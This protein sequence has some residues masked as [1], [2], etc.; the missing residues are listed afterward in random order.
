DYY[1]EGEGSLLTVAHLDSKAHATVSP[2]GLIDALDQ[3]TGL[4]YEIDPNAM[5]VG[6]GVNVVRREKFPA[7]RAIVQSGSKVEVKS[8]NDLLYFDGSKPVA[9]RRVCGYPQQG[10]ANYFAPWAI[11][12]VTHD[13]YGYCVRTNTLLILHGTKLVAHLSLANRPRSIAF[14]RRRNLVYLQSYGHVVTVLHGTKRVGTVHVPAEQTIGTPVVDPSTGD[15]YLPGYNIVYVV[16]RT[17]YLGSVA[18]GPLLVVDPATHRVYAG[19]NGAQ[20]L[21][22]KGAEVV[23]HVAT[24]ADPAVYDPMDRAVLAA[25]GTGLQVIHGAKVEQT[26]VIPRVTSASRIAVVPSR[27]LIVAT[28]GA[29]V[30]VL[31]S[32]AGASS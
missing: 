18:A 7:E 23:G 28:N 30:A 10:V 12:P 32:S 27:G 8:G 31:R 9:K 3:A 4:T 11:D 17:Q 29:V 26:V 21:L 20:I 1:I 5:A 6:R 13:T 22:L 16:H 24:T 25:T 19:G 15:V 2:P 14:D